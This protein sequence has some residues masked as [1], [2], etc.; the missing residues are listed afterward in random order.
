MEIVQTENLTKIYSDHKLPIRA[1]DDV[2]L[3]IEKG[4]FT[5]IA[6]PSGRESSCTSGRRIPVD[7]AEYSTARSC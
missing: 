1:L 4:E 5:A 2:N 3:S 7:E 6:G